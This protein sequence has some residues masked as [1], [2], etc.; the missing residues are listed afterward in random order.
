MTMF[1][2]D[3]DVWRRDDEIH[4]NVLVDATQI[5][6]VLRRS[7]VNAEVQISFGDEILPTGL[8]GSHRASTRV[9]L[10]RT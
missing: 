7:G 8:V 5:P 1:V 3:G 4:D 2:R 9:R 10:T 6:A